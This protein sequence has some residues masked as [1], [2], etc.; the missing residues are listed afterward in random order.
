MNFELTKE[1]RDIQRAA[2]EF[3]QAE[4]DKDAVLELERQHKFPWELFK[5]AA[6]LGFVGVDV[7]EE[8]EGQGYGLLE[9]VLVDEEFCRQ[10]AGIGESV[11]TSEVF[12]KLLLANGT[13]EQKKKYLPPIMRGEAIMS[14]AYTEPEG[15]SDITFLRTGA[16]KDGSDYIIS[17]N[18]IF[19]TYA[20]IARWAIV[21]CQTNPEAKP[22]YRG[23]SIILVELDKKGI[24]I[25]DFEKMGWHSAPTCNLIL[26]DVRVPQENLIGEENRGFYHAIQHLNYFR[27]VMAG[28][29][30]GVAQ[31]AFDRALEYAKIRE[32]FGQ[33]IGQFQAIQHRLAEMAVK[34]ETARLL[35][36]KSAWEFDQGRTEPKICSMAKLYT[37][38]VAIEVADAA[39]SIFGGHGYMLENEVERFYRD[40]RCYPIV[41]GTPDLHKNLIGRA[42]LGFK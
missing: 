33:K 15:G 8:Y 22:T 32:A 10:F 35:T 29:G 31:G 42:L 18:K 38:S 13:E 12:S 34:I 3:V 28:V 14:G 39:I 9:K 7:P 4:Y 24:D 11:V 6:G 17:G 16:I 21:L 20:S 41:E 27:V 30:L 26:S 23:Q 25:S 40:A 36:Y 19:T 1:Q 5:K 2:R 37:C